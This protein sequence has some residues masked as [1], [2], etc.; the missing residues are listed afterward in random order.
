MMSKKVLNSYL[1]RNQLLQVSVDHVQFEKFKFEDTGF[2]IHEYLFFVRKNKQVVKIVTSCPEFSSGF[3]FQNLRSVTF[4]KL[5]WPWLVNYLAYF[6]NKIQQ[7]NRERHRALVL[8]TISTHDIG[9][10][11]LMESFLIN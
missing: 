6:T 2:R 9:I 7:K 8:E 11:Y 5:N 1:G 3:V 10:C 4:P